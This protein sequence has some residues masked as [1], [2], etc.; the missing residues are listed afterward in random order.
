[1]INPKRFLKLLTFLRCMPIPKAS[2]IPNFT[3]TF[4]VKID[5]A[6]RLKLPSAIW[7]IIKERNKYNI[8]GEDFEISE[9]LGLYT[10]NYSGNPFATIESTSRVTKE[11]IDTRS[12]DNLVYLSAGKIETGKPNFNFVN[13]DAVFLYSAT[14]AQRM[15]HDEEGRVCGFRDN[16]HIAEMDNQRRIQLKRVLEDFD[17][18]VRAVADREHNAYVVGQPSLFCAVLIKYG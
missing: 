14:D 4:P 16:H 2:I 18:M 15:I 10:I 5:E 3:G 6:N 8:L 13:P 11:N 12:I 1:M 17:Y 9:H 7:E